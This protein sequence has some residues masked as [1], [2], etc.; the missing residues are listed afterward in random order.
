MAVL[1]RSAALFAALEFAQ[2]AETQN[3][4][5]RAFEEFIAKYNK[6]Y[7]TVKARATA[8]DAFCDSLAHVEAE[9]SKNNNFTLAINEFAD[10]TNEEWNGRLGLS[11][12]AG[13]LWGTAPHLGTDSYSGA[14][15][16][17]SVDW[18]KRGAVT[19]PKNQRNC[20][21]C[22]T[23]STTGALEGAWKIA[24]GKLVSLSEQ[25]LLDCSRGENKGCHGGNMDYAFTYL[26]TKPVCTESSYTY[27][28]KQGK[29]SIGKCKVAIR[30]GKVVGFRDVPEKNEKALM[31]A[32]SKQP[33]SI[34]VEADQPSFKLYSHGILTS[35]K[36]GSKL[37]HGVLLV[38]YGTEK[39]TPYWKVKN[40]WGSNFGEHGYIRLSRRVPG[41]GECGVMLMPS[42]PVLGKASGVDSIVV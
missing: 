27:T 35:N 6:T 14:P 16:A 34:G 17:S 37:D 9:N 23:F 10:Q 3:D 40:S 31:E 12:F 20:G 7:D 42:Y 24:S 18:V 28:A 30:A 32:V 21:A 5:N 8:A 11:T 2:A 25:Q 39:G 33:V 13:K 15:L 38:G 36:C 29:C 4:C 26:K 22:W 41:A 19:P 1:R